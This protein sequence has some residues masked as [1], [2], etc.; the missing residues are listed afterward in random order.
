[1]VGLPGSRSVVETLLMPS[2]LALRMEAVTPTVLTLE[3]MVARFMR[4]LLL[5]MRRSSIL[6]EDSERLVTSSWLHH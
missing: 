4:F 5:T 3:G 1:M 2:A 6:A